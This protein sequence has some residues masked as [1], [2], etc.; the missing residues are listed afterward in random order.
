MVIIVIEKVAN[1][2]LNGWKNEQQVVAVVGLSVSD[3]VVVVALEE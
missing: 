1:K 3:V 2:S